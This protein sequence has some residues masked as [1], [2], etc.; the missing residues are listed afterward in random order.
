MVGEGGGLK[1]RWYKVNSNTTAYAMD[2]NYTFTASAET[3]GLYY[4]N[5]S[6]EMGEV[7]SMNV[8]ILI[9]DAAGQ[10]H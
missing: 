10:R 8:N 1:Y 3:A 4:V 5:V 7:K 6:N 2:A 9:S